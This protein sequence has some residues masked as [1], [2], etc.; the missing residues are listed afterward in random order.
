MRARMVIFG[1]GRNSIVALEYFRFELHSMLLDLDDRFPEVPKKA[2]NA[3]E[4]ANET[5]KNGWN[6][7]DHDIARQ[8]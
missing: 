3:R 2:A 5:S 4:T 7:C 6:E 8:M 1:L